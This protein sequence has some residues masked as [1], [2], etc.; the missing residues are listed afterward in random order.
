MKHASSRQVFAY[1]NE[2]R[3]DRIAPDRADIEPGSIRRALGDTF[4]LGQDA[5]GAY[6]FRLAGTRS[7][8]LFCREL[9]AADF[10]AVWT[11]TERANM[12]QLV[13]AAAEESAGFVA[14]AVGRTAAGATVA[15]EILVLPL[16]HRKQTR[17]RLLGVLAP[18]EPPYWLGL[19]PIDAVSCDT[20]RYLGSD[21]RRIVA[22]RLVPGPDNADRYHGL[23]IYDGGRS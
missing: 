2:R 15:L 9:K 17:A 5:Q 11:E 13:T 8:A 19:T 7:C 18:L 14:G 22:P 1:W 6:R 10:L 20:I 4:I 16:R 23:T 3:G 21:S 12:L